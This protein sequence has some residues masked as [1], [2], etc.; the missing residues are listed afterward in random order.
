M[1]HPTDSFRKHEPDARAAEWE[2]AG[3][4]W[5]RVTDGAAVVRVLGSGSWHVDL[6]RLEA[7]PP[8]RDAAERFGRALAVTHAA[9]ASAFGV[10][11]DGWHSDGVQGPADQSVAL[12]LAPRDSW[13]EMYAD[14]RIEPLVAQAGF[15]A[16]DRS[17]FD[18]LCARLRDGEFD[19]GE[20]PARVHGDLWSGNLMWTPTG[21]VLIDPM[22]HASHREVDLAALSLFGC[23]Q[24]DRITGSY[25]EADPLADGWRDRV[26]LMQL[27][28]VLLHVVLFG[29]GYASQA[30]SIARRYV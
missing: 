10:G 5:L 30:L 24:L 18:R 6:Q 23:P 12:P 20:P 17:V 1:A 8:T 3:L 16:S 15:S 26:P 13:G 2:V 28:L 29:G 9:G 4:E 27:H 25:N 19:T 21:C 14:L 22:A 11:P 7:A